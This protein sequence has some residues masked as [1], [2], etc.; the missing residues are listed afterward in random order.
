[1]R[2]HELNEVWQLTSAELESI[3]RE[4]HPDLSATASGSACV[5]FYEKKGQTDASAN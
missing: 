4:Y 2:P 1:M 3:V 5:I